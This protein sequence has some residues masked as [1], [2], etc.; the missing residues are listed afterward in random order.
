MEKVTADFDIIFTTDDPNTV[1]TVK[2]YLRSTSAPDAAHAGVINV[3]AGKYRHVILPRLATTAVGAPDSTKR[4]YWGIASSKMSSL[5]YG[6]WEAPHM[7]APA[8]GS[9]A[10]DIQTDD[11]EFRSRGG[12]GICVVSSAWIKFSSGDATS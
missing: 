10:E 11:W 12:I 6:V 9:N 3:Y 1:N 2:E 7:I 4:G 5:H 8:N